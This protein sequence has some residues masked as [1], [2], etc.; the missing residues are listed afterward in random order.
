MKYHIVVFGC[1]M[2][3]SDAERIASVLESIKYKK[4]SNINEADLIVVTM[5]SVR[6][7]AV[8]RVYGLD[9]KFRKLKD[10]NK[11]L[12]TILTLQLLAEIFMAIAFKHLIT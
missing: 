6:Q 5:C 1:Q 11:Q 9:E 4:T 8:D 12:I 3:L 7:S 10:S 2:N